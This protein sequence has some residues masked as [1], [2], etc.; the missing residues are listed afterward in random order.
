MTDTVKVASIGIGWWSNVL[1][2]AVK[3]DDHIEIVT[4]YTRSDPKRKRFADKYGCGQESSYEDVLKRPDVDAVLLTTPNQVHAEQIIAAAEAGKHVFADK[5]MTLT[6]Q[7]ARRVVEACKQHGVIL[8]V[9]HSRRRSAG[10][11][12]MKQLIDQGALG[13]PIAVEANLSFGMGLTLTKQQWRWNRKESP[14]GP[15]MS[16]G[17]H[18]IDNLHYLLGPIARVSSFFG[19]L[20]TPSPIEDVTSTIFEFKSGVLGYLGCNFATPKVYMLNVQGTEANLYGGDEGNSLFIQKKPLDLNTS[21][22]EPQHEAIPLTPVDIVLEEIREFARCV[23]TGQRPEV[24][25]EE[26]LNAIAVVE[27]MV[28]SAQQKGSVEVNGLLG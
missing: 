2:D 13:T 24:S 18:H 5:P 7:E 9:G 1:A 4:C 21:Y 25:G 3:Q 22:V 6:T 10:V 20:A 19:R 16:L 23:Q 26:G 8:A 17:I 12:K 11:R 28:Q 27:A 14:G 15:L